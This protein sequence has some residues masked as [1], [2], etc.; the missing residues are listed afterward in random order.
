MTH[1]QAA[2]KKKAFLESFA[3]IGIVST[4]AVEAGIA[5]RTVYSWQ[6]V[7][8]EFAAAFRQAEIEATEAME[9][10][11][12][13]RGVLGTEKP[14]Y[15]G[16]VKV[17]TVREFSD[18]LLIFMLKARNPGKYRERHPGAD[19]DTVPLKTVDQAAYEAL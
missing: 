4:A 1:A 10:E 13:R 16:G 14:V 17:G 3:R 5:R 12:Y 19:A 15:Q 9:Q 8:D 7:D 11:A 6:E 18:V 2:Q